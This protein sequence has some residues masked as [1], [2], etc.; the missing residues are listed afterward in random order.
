M[1]EKQKII[2]GQAVR[3]EYGD[4]GCFGELIPLEVLENK[5]NWKNVAIVCFGYTGNY[6]PK[7]KT[8]NLCLDTRSYELVGF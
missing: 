4:D 2:K 7:D 8:I 1:L 3:L 5:Y 6:F